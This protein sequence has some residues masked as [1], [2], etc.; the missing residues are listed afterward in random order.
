[1]SN[2]LN[3]GKSALTSANIAISTIG[4]N[5]ANATT[6][7][8]NRQVVQAAIAGQSTGSGYIG[9]GTEV[10]A[11]TR[12]Y[13]EFM[14]NQVL[15]A[16]TYKSQLD[17]YY[18][19]IKQIDNMLA[20]ST[21]G[22]S[23]S[24][25][26]FF[27]GVQDL[28][29]SAGSATARQSL[30]S[31]A[32]TLVANFQN[33]D[34]QLREMG[35]GVN[36]Q[37]TSSV[38]AINAYSKQI[39]QLNEA[40][41]KSPGLTDGNM[42]N[43]LLDQR[44][45]AIANLSKE[46]KVS[47]VKQGNSF[48]IYVGSGQPLVI[49]ANTYDLKAVPST[50]DSSRMEVAYVNNGKTTTLAE[51][52][53]TGGKL[54]GLFEFRR[55]T[56]D[57]AQN[58]LGRVAIVLASDINAQH[59]LG[60]DLNGDPGGAFFNLDPVSVTANSKNTGNGVVTD[61]I[62]DPGKLTTS[63]YQLKFDGTNYTVTR[64]SDSAKWTG[65]SLTAL[66]NTA[67]EGFD[68]GFSLSTS[69]VPDNGDSFLIRPTVNGASGISV[70]ITNT[71]KIAAAAPITTAATATNTGSGKISAGVVNSAPASAAATLT[72]S[73]GNITTTVALTMTI[74]GGTPVNYAA[75]ASVPYTEGATISFGGVS[76]VLTGTPA[77]GDTFT[78]GPNTDGVGDNRNAL[79]MGALQTAN[80]V[81]TTNYQ[82]AYSQLVNLIG[83][84]TSELESTST[85]AGNVLTQSVESQQAMS[86]VNLDEEATNLMRYQQAYQAAAK[87]IKT[88]GDLFDTLLSLGN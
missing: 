8:Y 85:A 47:V 6:P 84:K 36:D 34:S 37:I 25:Q 46:I 18:T 4:N 17:T 2:I 57:V 16:Q 7:G 43:T 63:D 80:K 70:A 10:T 42:P 74:N 30:L 81:G 35:E 86:G 62:D 71:S 31:S 48:D 51:S 27:K 54:G 19:Q 21:V 15:S 60:M 9:K 59:Q 38:T 23:P 82:G 12:V 44:D 73:G 41:E 66:S 5:I 68:E 61:T 72:Y 20:D 58:S 65:T 83:N 3:I 39:A 56:L 14:G 53:L 11:I 13:S 32:E 76:V 52:S 49:G 87:L 78:V 26:G 29:A 1:M 22:L 50:T 33:M 69:P 64:L 24:L 28:S 75:G 55:E 88:A 40:I 79:L 45:L 67:G 77:N